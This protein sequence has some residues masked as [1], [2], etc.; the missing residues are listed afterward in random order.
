VTFT[1][2]PPY[3]ELER[4]RNSVVKALEAD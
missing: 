3:L 2:P 1:L 4:S